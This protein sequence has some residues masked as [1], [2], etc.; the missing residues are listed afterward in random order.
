VPTYQEA[1]S[2][3][4]LADQWLGVFIPAGTTPAI[5]DRLNAEINHALADAAVR[6]SFLQSAQEPLGGTRA[7]FARFVRDE[8]EK[9]GRLVQQLDIKVN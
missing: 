4:L 7:E 2:K 5:A 1:G 6:E 3:G 9:Y 8:Y